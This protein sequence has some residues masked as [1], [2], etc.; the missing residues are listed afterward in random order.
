MLGCTDAA[1]CNYDNTAN[2]ED[3]TCTYPAENEDCDGNCIAGVD[4]Q[5]ICGGTAAIDNCGICGGDDSTCTG[6]TE[7]GSQQLR[8][9]ATLD[10]GSCELPLCLGDLNADLLVSVADILEMLGEFGCTENC[11]TDLSGDEAVSVDDL[12]LLLANFGLECTD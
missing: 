4:C 12:L 5:G 1:A 8:S 9:E 11:E 10:D 6:C 2:E 7:P 3:G